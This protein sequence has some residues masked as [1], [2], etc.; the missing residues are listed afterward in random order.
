MRSLRGFNCWAEP[1]ADDASFV[2]SMS[3][4]EPYRVKSVSFSPNLH[5]STPGDLAA[6]S[7]LQFGNQR[8]AVRRANP[9]LAAS[10][11]I[12]VA[13][14][15]RA[16]SCRA[17]IPGMTT[18]A[19]P[20]PPVPIVQ[21]NKKGDY[22]FYGDK[23]GDGFQNQGP[24]ELVSFGRGGQTVVPIGIPDYDAR[25]GTWLAGDFNGDG[26]TDLAHLVLN[27]PNHDPYLHVHFSKGKGVFAPPTPGFNFRAVANPQHDYNAN[28]GNWYVQY[29]SVNRR[30]MLVHDPKLPD[31]RR[32]AWRSNGDG[33]FAVGSVQ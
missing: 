7:L 17:T 10:I 6:G 18:L 12:N 20:P 5:L 22:N 33:T 25:L 13:S 8:I 21:C 27:W 26:I 23:C 32:H 2:I 11:T 16:D 31:N 14:Q 24:V 15:Y 1:E 9:Q 28:L 3:E 4:P 30:D 29:D 19:P